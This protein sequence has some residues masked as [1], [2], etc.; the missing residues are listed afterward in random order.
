MKRKE[1]FLSAVEILAVGDKFIIKA[2]QLVRED[3]LPFK[4]GGVASEFATIMEKLRPFLSQRRTQAKA[5]SP[6]QL[7]LQSR[8]SSAFG[9]ARE[10][11]HAQVQMRLENAPRVK[12]AEFWLKLG[13]PVQALCEL[14]KLPK[15]ARNQPWALRVNVTAIGSVREMNS[16]AHVER[17]SRHRN[18]LKTTGDEKSQ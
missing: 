13:Q 3:A 15:S 5:L 11:D 12:S 4:P 16:Q 10:Q 14:N 2:A 9:N 17:I 1:Q 7:G 8:V 6:I 18:D